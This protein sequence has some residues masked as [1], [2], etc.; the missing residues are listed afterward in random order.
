MA[1]ILS[2][3]RMCEHLV[4]R[5]LIVQPKGGVFPFTFQKM[6]YLPQEEKKINRIFVRKTIFRGFLLAETVSSWYSSFCKKP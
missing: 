3:G 5:D 1:L 4:F 6:N 2:E